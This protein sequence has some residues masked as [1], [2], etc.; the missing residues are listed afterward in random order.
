[1]HPRVHEKNNN[2]KKFRPCP[3]RTTMDTLAVAG[4]VLCKVGCVDPDHDLQQRTACY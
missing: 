2:T 3:F 1:M 4:N